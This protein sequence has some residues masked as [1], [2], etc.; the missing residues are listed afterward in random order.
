MSVARARYCMSG[1]YMY[2]CACM[3]HVRCMISGSGYS[4][5][6]CDCRCGRS[7]LVVVQV[8]MVKPEDPGCQAPSRGWLYRK[9]NDDG[10]LN[11]R[12][13]NSLAKECRCFV[14]CHRKAVQPGRQLRLEAWRVCPPGT[15]PTLPDP[16]GINGQPHTQPGTDSTQQRT[17]QHTTPHNN[18][19]CCTHAQLHNNVH[20]LVTTCTPRT[21]HAHT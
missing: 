7:L 17:P 13:C 5:R 1:I 21:H 12:Y 11:C 4:A 19:Q 16:G 8:H 3:V 9:Y 20:T 15:P 2:V 10:D 14:D 6:A 18:Q